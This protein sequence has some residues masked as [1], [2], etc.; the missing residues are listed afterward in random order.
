MG[1]N[2]LHLIGLEERGKIA[3]KQKMS[4]GRRVAWFD[5]TPPCLV[6]VEA[7]VGVYHLTH[8]LIALGQEGDV[9]GHLQLLGDMPSGAIENEDRVGAGSDGL[10]DLLEINLHGR[11][12]RA[13]R[14]R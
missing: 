1:K 4:R 2:T 6:G 12:A 10:G 9:V 3:L 8:E 5:N 11:R 7:C 13:T 14:R